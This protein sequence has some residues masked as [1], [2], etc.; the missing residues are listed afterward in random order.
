MSSKLLIPEQVSCIKGRYKAA[1]EIKK[2]RRWRNGIDYFTG[3]GVSKVRSI[4][5]ICRK[6]EKE[7]E[8]RACSLC[9]NVVG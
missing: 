9:I 3:Y 2:K 7:P 1:L 5:T 4:C 8:E 6:V